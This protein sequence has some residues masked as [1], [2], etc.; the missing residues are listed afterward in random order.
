MARPMTDGEKA[1]QTTRLKKVIC[2]VDNYIARISRSTLITYG[3][4]ICPAC[5]QAMKE[6]K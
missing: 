5:N 4:P 2:E 3:S 6:V 1:K